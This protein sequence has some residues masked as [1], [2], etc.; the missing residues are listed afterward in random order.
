[1]FVAGSG[2]RRD[3]WQSS[4]ALSHSRTTRPRRGKLEPS[5]ATKSA[6]RVGRGGRRCRRRRPQVLVAEVAR[7]G[8]AALPAAV[9]PS[10]IDGTPQSRASPVAVSPSVPFELLVSPTR[11]ST[12]WPPYA[13]NGAEAHGAADDQGRVSCLDRRRQDNAQRPSAASRGPP[14]GLDDQTARNAD[15]AVT[16]ALLALSVPGMI[17]R[18]GASLHAKV[19]RRLLDIF[20]NGDLRI[21]L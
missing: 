21:Y 3:L 4:R 1:M 10:G 6:R 2:T 12:G 14:A 9:P 13:R 11:W 8:R 7:R 17:Q 19:C 15:E 20:N 18:R 16:M 5:R